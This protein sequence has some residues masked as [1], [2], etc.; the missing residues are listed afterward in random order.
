MIMRKPSRRKPFR[1]KLFRI[2]LCRPSSRTLGT[3]MLLLLSAALT[4]H[5][6]AAAAESAVLGVYASHAAGAGTAPGNSAGSAEDQAELAENSRDAGLLIDWHLMGRY[7]HGSPDDFARPFAPERWAA[8]E[9]AKEAAKQAAKQAAN[10]TA[11]PPSNRFPERHFNVRRYELV[12]PQGTFVLPPKLAERQGVFYALSR[13]YL[14]GGGEWNVYLESGADATV[15][16]DGNL[17][18]TRGTSATGTLRE[19]IHAARGYHLVMVKFVAQAA[20]FRV[21]ILPPSS[22][23]RRKNNTPYLQRSPTQDDLR[24]AERRGGQPM[25]ARPGR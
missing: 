3:V 7:G 17:V 15:F 19:T 5:P 9:A 11:H 16:V 14:T 1:R 10:P 12:F 20:P 25:A 22:G 18:L 13:A 8:K 2:A 23:S 6:A 4:A 24:A 21:A